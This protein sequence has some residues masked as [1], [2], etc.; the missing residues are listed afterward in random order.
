M[1]TN[2]LRG[3]TTNASARRGRAPTT[4]AAGRQVVIEVAGIAIRMRLHST[5]T[6]QRILA[7]LPL[8]ATA[9]TWG[10]SLHFE[11]P[12]KTGRERNARLNVKAGDICYW[13]EDS[14]VVIGWGP[15]PIS[16]PDEIRLMRPCNVW[17]TALDDVRLLATVTPGEKVTLRALDDLELG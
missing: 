6:A 8:F 4:A 12:I 14:R 2:I 10:E 13:S 16:M 7:G 9:E 15:T 17:A 1:P 3:V 5:L 11:I